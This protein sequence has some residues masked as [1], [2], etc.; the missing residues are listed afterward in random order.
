M[1]IKQLDEKIDRLISIVARIIKMD[2]DELKSY[3][4]NKSISDR[5]KKISR[6]TNL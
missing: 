5:V 6:Q 4:E 2:E 1:T 3:S